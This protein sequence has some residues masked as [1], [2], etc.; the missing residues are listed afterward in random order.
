MT[1]HSSNEDVITLTGNVAHIEGVGS[2]EITVS[3]GGNENYN[4]AED[5]QRSVTVVKV[6]QTISFDELPAMSTQDSPFELTASSTSNLLITY[7]SSEPSV[8]TV[9]ESTITL[10]GKG[11]TTI[12]ASQGGNSTYEVALGV[13]RTLTV[14]A[15]DQVFFSDNYPQ[16]EY[17]QSNTYRLLLSLTETG[18][19]YYIVEPNGSTQPTSEQVKAGKNTSGEDAFKKGVAFDL[20]PETEY[21][22]AQINDLAEGNSYDIYLVLADE[23]YALQA[24]ITKLAV[25]TDDNTAPAWSEG[26]PQMGTIAL[27]EA[28]VQID[29]NEETGN[30]YYAVFESS[31]TTRSPANLK[32][33]SNSQAI[34]EGFVSAS[35]TG[36]TLTNLSEGNDYDVWLVAEDADE[37]LQPTAT[38]IDF[39]TV[40]NLI[41]WSGTAWSNGTGPTLN[42]DAKLDAPLTTASHGAFNA[43]SLEVSSSAFLR[44]STGHTLEVAG[45]VVVNG[46]MIIES[47]A[48]LI[49][50]DG[51]SIAD[52]IYFS[53]N[54]RYSDGKYSFVGSPVKQNADITTSD[55]GT[56]VYTYNEA[57]SSDMMSLSR[58]MSPS[59]TDQLI[60]GKGYTQSH[61]QLID[62]RGEPNAGTITYSG[63]YANDGWHLVSNPYAAAVFID[64]FLDANT[65][66]TDAV[67]IWD[68]NG[69]EQSRGSNSDYIVANKTGATDVSG[70]N[71][72]SRWN[73]HIGSAQGFFVKLDS[74]AGDIT[75]KETMR[76]A[77]NNGDGNFYR[78][79]EEKSTIRINLTNKE[80]LFKQAL[81]GWNEEVSDTEITTGYDAP[82][83]NIN[84]EHAIY[85]MK[86]DQP[87]T[88]QTI[89]SAR[90]KIP[91]GIN[92]GEAGHYTIAANTAA[93]GGSI[94]YLQ[95]QHTGDVF[96]LMN[97]NYTFQSGAGQLKDR[98]MLLSALDVL[99]VSN[100]L[101]KLY[102]HKKTL[103]I[104]QT[105]L[106]PVSYQLF[107]LSG[108]HV[109]QIQTTSDQVDL[110][111]LPDGIYL[112]SDSMETKKIVLK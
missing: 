45:D 4:P 106:Q 5:M 35:A 27:S 104:K 10:V 103:Y 88:I 29:L 95:D 85:T 98:F 52:D 86:A 6:P 68:D 46:E 56:N 57:Q 84:A 82:M 92:I 38:K 80:G 102:T 54:T 60:P 42:D 101:P 91:L 74:S 44:I 67:Y 41:T 93:Y 16:F 81:I 7:Q 2:A 13:E 87:L 59:G 69:S 83:F 109:L 76:R 77:G 48:S 55:L 99:K 24:N 64:A 32:N 111:Q 112:I 37:N 100:N 72:E 15:E 61:Q 71:N 20:A 107:D 49:T 90:T 75:F 39:T 9:S 28:E 70:S 31:S 51:N 17:F 110:S 108:K 63:S 73:D 25:M 66:T 105:G 58:W 62:Y 47:G 94:F 97:G 22:Q 50:Y 89:T 26:Y 96:D 65:N 14:T 19:V 30:V 53:R 40:S 3:Q 78:K 43:N 11:T 1:Y 33:G 36:F 21:N 79:A 34:N 8:A 23:T 18:S 12:T